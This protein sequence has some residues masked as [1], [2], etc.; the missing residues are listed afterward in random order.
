MAIDLT[1]LS[2]AQAAS[3]RN[4]VSDTSAKV[5]E[6]DGGSQPTQSAKSGGDTVK[7]SEAA[8]A[9]QAAEKKIGSTPDVDTDRVAALKSAIESG[10]YQINYEN[11]AKG[12]VELESLLD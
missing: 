10:S 11:V 7:L 9:V 4:K 2:S 6:N 12:L 8:Q 5:Q 3:T 1:S